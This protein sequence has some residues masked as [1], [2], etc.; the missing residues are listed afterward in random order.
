MAGDNWLTTVNSLL[1]QGRVEDAQEELIKVVNTDATNIRAWVTLAETISIPSDRKLVLEEALRLNPGNLEIQLM[2]KGGTDAEDKTSE[3]AAPAEPAESQ[4]QADNFFS[5]AAPTG[6]AFTFSP[7]EWEAFR[8]EP[9]KTEEP[10]QEVYTPPAFLSETDEDNAWLESLRSVPWNGQAGGEAP[11]GEAEPKAGTESGDLPLSSFS[12]DI[13]TPAEPEAKPAPEAEPNL[14]D[15]VWKASEPEEEADEVGFNGRIFSSESEK[16]PEKPSS[17]SSFG[18]PPPT[19]SYSQADE[20]LRLDLE[21]ES[22]EEAPQEAERM[23][24]DISL[25]DLEEPPPPKRTWLVVLLAFVIIAAIGGGGYLAW[26]SIS[27]LLTPAAVVAPEPTGEVTPMTPT[28]TLTP[29][30]TFTPSPTV[31]RTPTQA[32]WTATPTQLPALSRIVPLTQQN[33]AQFKLVTSVKGHAE[34]SPDGKV[35]V[36]LADALT[37]RVWDVLKEEMRFEVKGPRAPIQS[38][39]VSLDGKLV[40]AASEEPAVYL[41]NAETGIAAGTLEFGKELVDYFKDKTF[42]HTLQIQFGPDGKTL[43]ATSLL[44]LT[45]W[46]LQSK[47]EQ[48]LYPLTPAELVTFREQALTGKNGRASSFLMDFAPDGKSLAIGSPF[49]VYLLFWPTGNAWTSLATKAPLIDMK[50][51]ASNLLA[52]EQPGVMTIW[53]TLSARQLLSYTGLKSLQVQ[54]APPASAYRPDGKMIAVESENARG[55]AGMLRLIEMP[56]G[57]VVSTIDPNMSAPIENPLFS[58]DG[59]LLMA[60]SGGDLFVWDVA[61]GSQLRRIANRRGFVDILG[62]GRFYV[63]YSTVDTVLFSA[64]P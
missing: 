10:A 35:A 13:S 17:S 2:L 9:E 19:F 60:R 62:D 32:P 58:L 31:T 50:F 27:V 56:S 5:D 6:G 23:L 20:P 57:K 37:V 55:Q 4:K 63:E 44:G 8:T 59:K 48:H 3:P 61:T 16:A 47:K 39:A 21:G 30:V 14:A 38:L 18:T 28:V 43:A 49:K 7:E 34:F 1:K 46:D 33:L 42:S 24:G 45:W 15:L 29:T 41:W 54:E 25:Q 36:S 53:E 11:A 64:V 52:L 22:E 26:P 12:W 40:A 51:F